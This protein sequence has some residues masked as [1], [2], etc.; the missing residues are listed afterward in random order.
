MLIKTTK[1]RNA[2]VCHRE[3]IDTPRMSM[4]THTSHEL[5]HYHFGDIYPDICFMTFL[6]VSIN[7]WS[8]P[9]AGTERL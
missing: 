5:D 2:S 3:C 4:L 1:Y 8:G 9:L 7:Y 6:L